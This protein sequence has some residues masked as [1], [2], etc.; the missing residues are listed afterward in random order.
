[1]HAVRLHAFGPAENLV[2]EEVADPHPAPGEVAIAVAAAG[3]HLVDT[4]LRAG[5]DAAGG[6]FP[7]PELPTVPGRE[8]AG[9]VDE[10]GEGVDPAWLGRRVSAHLGM[11]P[12]GY[13]ERAVTA[14]GNLHRLPEGMTAETAVAMLGTGRMTMGI[15]RFAELTAEDT[16]LV[17]AAAGGIGALLVQY[18]R[19]RGARVAGAAGGPA[20]AAAVARLGA[21]LAVDYNRPDWADTLREAYGER[22]FSLLCEGVGGE[23]GR[24]AL[25]L[26]A[27]GG[28]HLSYGYASTGA[29]PRGAVAP[30]PEE[31]AARGI[32][33]TSVL[34]PALFEKI[35][36]RENLRL[37][38][39][40]ALALAAAG[41]LV[42]LVETFPLAEAARAHRALE[43][44]A[45]TGKVVLVP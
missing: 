8:V 35:G 18:A 36:G 41:T 26:L 4:V 15:L 7:V 13:A 24:T 42:P 25:G 2:Y 34:G 44:R 16:V 37:L 11:V 23:F 9:T 10:V 31:L 19:H 20:K 45:T 1:M 3:V 6:A 21:D 14:I 43:S 22:P 5:P 33:S 38:E 39:E 12:G 32:S 27:P 17:L 29:S 30:S 40:E 28:R